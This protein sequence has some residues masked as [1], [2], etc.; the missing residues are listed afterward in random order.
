VE[1]L[2][3]EGEAVL[4]GFKPGFDREALDELIAVERECCPFFEFGLDEERRRLRVTVRDPEFAPALDAI[5]AQ[6]RPAA[7]K[8]AR[9][10]GPVGTAARI[11]T[12][13]AL[14]FIAGG[15]TFSS[16]AI[17]LDEVLI[18]LGA[19]PA[20]VV[21]LGLVA[22]RFAPDPIRLTGPLGIALNLAVIVALI[23]NDVTGPEG[24]VIFYGATM[25]I[26]AFR[27]QPGCEATVVSNLVLGRDDQIGCPMFEPIDELEAQLRRRRTAAAE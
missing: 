13:L 10:I 12:A 9:E 5:A 23:A 17:D 25:L 7:R 18:G 16:W 27:G 8:P 19:L 24:A 2:A 15:A 14:F 6:I 11:L 1:E 26:A 4:V 20:V 22:Q 21:A 3:R